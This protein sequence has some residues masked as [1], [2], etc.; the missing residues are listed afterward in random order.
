M[1]RDEM[2]GLMF[3]ACIFANIVF[4]TVMKYMN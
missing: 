3:L 1:S 2:F 4:H